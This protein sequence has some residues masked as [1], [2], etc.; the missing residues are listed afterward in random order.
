MPFDTDDEN[1]SPLR[2]GR[3]AGSS[4]GGSSPRRSL[5][6]SKSVKDL[7]A[8]WENRSSRSFI[9]NDIS[10]IEVLRNNFIQQS[11]GIGSGLLKHLAMLED[12]GVSNFV[13][14]KHKQA[15]NTR[16]EEA[17]WKGS[18]TKAKSIKRAAA[19]LGWLTEYKQ[20]SEGDLTR[21]YS[22]ETLSKVSEKDRERLSEVY[23]R[24]DL[25]KFGTRQYLTFERQTLG[26]IDEMI[27]VG[28]YKVKGFG[29]KDKV[30]FRIIEDKTGQQFMLRY[31]DFHSS[32]FV[33][34]R[35][36]PVSASTKQFESRVQPY[37]QKRRD[38]AR[39]FRET[40][41][42]Q[43]LITL[44]NGTSYY[45]YTRLQNI[46][47]ENLDK[48]IRLLPYDSVTKKVQNN[49]T[50][51]CNELGY[52]I[53]GDV[54]LQLSLL[55][56]DLP[57]TAYAYLGHALFKTEGEFTK[58]TLIS[59]LQKLYSD[60]LS[61]SK[62][63]NFHENIKLSMYVQAAINNLNKKD[64]KAFTS[65]TVVARL[66][67]ITLLDAAIALAINGE[68]LHG[69]EAGSPLFPENILV[70][71]IPNPKNPKSSLLVHGEFE[72]LQVLL[73][74]PAFENKIMSYNPCHFVVGDFRKDSYKEDKE[75]EVVKSENGSYKTL[76][77][78]DAIGII[79][80]IDDIYTRQ[81]GSTFARVKVDSTISFDG[82]SHPSLNKTDEQYIIK[83]HRLILE[84]NLLML[85]F[86]YSPEEFTK[87]VEVLQGNFA[88]MR[89]NLFT[90]KFPTLET[91]FDKGMKVIN[92]V[93][94]DVNNR[95]DIDVRLAE[96]KKITEQHSV[97]GFKRNLSGIDFD[98]NPL[99]RKQ[100][101]SIGSDYQPK[102]RMST[103]TTLR[104]TR[105]RS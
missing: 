64:G 20:Y 61:L 96:I 17:V 26:Y 53:K 38:R 89:N 87:Y 94:N 46:I 18:E 104:P 32:K 16:H 1:I 49:P 98:P 60:L 19:E 37:D 97:A 101:D 7:T 65:D 14:A 13:R 21:T 40:T 73:T 33:T 34:G 44:P 6:E 100:S 86:K 47:S 99:K 3:S 75:I 82:K 66:G 11:Y 77:A 51:N 10:S 48:T 43:Q 63:D 31:E 95:L 83:M 54:D 90:D 71:Q 15:L 29:Y 23:T 36:S 30:F 68:I 74:R 42:P 52:R 22:D 80:P 35:G 28:K 27:A 93:I 67:T 70:T 59:A 4:Q 5:H 85:K 8:L 92:S 50:I 79:G 88:V 39:S 24:P 45:T 58:Q 25:D 91:T 56:T 69:S 78:D 76:D 81:D 2:N 12:I 84:R 55:P 72:L 62:D 105:P 9:D 57:I 102:R 41:G 103:N